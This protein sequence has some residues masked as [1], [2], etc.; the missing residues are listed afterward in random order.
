MVITFKDNLVLVDIDGKR[1]TNFDPDSKEVPKDRQWFEPKREP[2][3]P[4]TGFIGLQNHDP[5][6]TVYF[7]EVSVRA[8]WNTSPRPKHGNS[9]KTSRVRR[10]PPDGRQAR[11]CGA[12]RRLWANKDPVPPGDWRR[13]RKAKR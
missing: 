11:A 3:R 1:T 5:V 8:A 9:F 6:D 13:E 4:K 7:K 10:V 12:G 2:K